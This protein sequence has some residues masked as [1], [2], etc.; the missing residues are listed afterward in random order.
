[1]YL[2]RK[3]DEFLLDWKSNPKRKPLIVKGCRQ[4]GK[5]ESIT[6]FAHEN[7]SN[8]IS[9]NF[10]EESKYKVILEDGYS[11][12]NIIK[13]ISRINPKFKFIPNETI[14]VFDEFQELSEMSTALK[15]FCIDNKYDVICS[16][17]LLVIHYKK[18]ESNSVDNKIDYEMTSLD[19]EEFLWA[20]NI[21]ITLFKIS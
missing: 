3:I 18:I 8:V 2:K 4:I 20:K 10:V 1:M 13:N 17:S 7:Y 16:G 14:I 11:V 9:I 12:A 21:M 6:K 15:F 5:T 19:F